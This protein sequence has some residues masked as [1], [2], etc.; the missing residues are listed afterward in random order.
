L[1]TRPA[2]YEVD[3]LSDGV[4]LSTR[5]PAGGHRVDRAQKRLF[6]RTGSD[7]PHTR[8]IL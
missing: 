7:R 3:F 4:R 1:V 8:V 6:Y 2:P 5:W